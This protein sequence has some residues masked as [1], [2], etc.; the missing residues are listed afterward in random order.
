MVRL[1]SSTFSAVSISGNQSLINRGGVAPDI[2]SRRKETF[3]EL[4]FD[5]CG[6]GSNSNVSAPILFE[7]LSSV[8]DG[9]LDV[10]GICSHGLPSAGCDVC[11]GEWI[12]SNGLKGCEQ[13]TPGGGRATVEQSTAFS[14]CCFLCALVWHLFAN[15]F[16]SHFPGVTRCR[17]LRHFILKNSRQLVSADFSLPL[18]FWVSWTR[19]IMD[20]SSDSNWTL[21]VATLCSMFWELWKVCSCCISLSC[22]TLR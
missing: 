13:S 19:S 22:K 17:Y 12:F 4:N 5:G 6:Q 14:P 18:A 11:H 10:H 21:S 15:P 9:A 20:G 7:I 1:E 8:L 2:T 16:T 3:H